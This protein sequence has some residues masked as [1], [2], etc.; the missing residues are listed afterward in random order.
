M[1]M[2]ASDSAALVTATQIA[3]FG[4]NR[5]E[6]RGFGGSEPLLKRH[7]RTLSRR[8]REPCPAYRIALVADWASP[9]PLRTQVLGPAFQSGGAFFLRRARERSPAL[10]PLGDSLHNLK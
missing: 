1:K 6:R 8:S 9:R 7:S 10:G 3:G 4:G 2:C 5:F